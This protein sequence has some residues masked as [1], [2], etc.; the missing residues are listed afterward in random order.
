[1]GVKTTKRKS[2]HSARYARTKPLKSF[3]ELIQSSELRAWKQVARQRSSLPR[4]RYHSSRIPKGL[5][6]DA[7]ISLIEYEQA[8]P[9]QGLCLCKWEHLRKGQFDLI[10][11]SDSIEGV[12][13]WEKKFKF[14]SFPTVVGL[15]SGRIC[16]AAEEDMAKCV[17]ATLYFC[18]HEGITSWELG[19][20]K[21]LKDLRLFSLLE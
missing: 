6:C 12:G 11:D 7:V 16:V 19:A 20:M 21:E 13:F 8:D 10:S 18:P 1:M 15:I 9:C 2:A 14:W 17:I 4:K 3:H 5:L